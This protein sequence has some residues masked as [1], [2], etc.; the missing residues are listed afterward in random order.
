L[1][2]TTLRRR[3]LAGAAGLAIGLSGALA[4]SLPAQAGGHQQPKPAGK[5]V[6]QGCDGIKVKVDVKGTYTKWRIVN[7]DGKELWK[8][9]GEVWNKPGFDIEKLI[10]PEDAHG[11]K[12][13]Y[14]KYG[15]WTRLDKVTGN[16]D[17]QAPPGAWPECGDSPSVE[18]VEDCDGNVAVT[19]NAGNTRRTW[20]VDGNDEE[21]K[22]LEVG[23]TRVWTADSIDAL[24]EW[25]HENSKE[26]K[27][28]DE[29]Y[30]T[31]TPAEDCPEETTPPEDEP[32]E[33]TPP[34]DE[35]EGGELPKTG[36]P[37][38]LIAAGAALM[39]TAGAGMYLVARRRRITFTA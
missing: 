23:E 18:I 30:V 11:L 16:G 19:V 1:T 6:D 27:Q 21:K 13:E 4:L 15:K 39:L 2:H 26:W 37:T 17:W 29:S 14:K 24:V 28:A 32:E 5:F 3:L 34:E 22:F 33:T 9:S 10:A 38:G 35:G 20:R 8:S 31:R 25:F 7:G 12:I 36:A